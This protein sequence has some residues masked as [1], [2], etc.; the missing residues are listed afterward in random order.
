MATIWKLK[1]LN[2]NI[3]NVNY[4]EEKTF[5]GLNCIYHFQMKLYFANGFTKFQILNF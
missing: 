1:I 4:Y 2:R 3:I 5:Q